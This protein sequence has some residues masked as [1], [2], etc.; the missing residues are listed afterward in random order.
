LLSGF[1]I[2]R[3]TLAGDRWR[4]SL[5]IVGSGKTSL[6]T[7]RSFGDASGEAIGRYA[8][9][10]PAPELAGLV[11]AAGATLDGGPPPRLS[12]EDVR[13]VITIVACGSQLT[14]VV[15]GGPPALEPYQPL[16]VAL[17][18][19]AVATR[20]QPQAVV[21]L[22]LE[23]PPLVAAGPHTL[24][25]VL[26]FHNPGSAGAWLRNPAAI[27]EDS[28]REHVRL[29][30]AERPVEQ[31]GV[32]PLPLEPAW[33]PVVPEMRA[34]RPLL[35]LGPGEREARPFTAQL[36]LDPGSYLV[37]ASFA[38]YAG[39]DSVGGQ[40]LLRGCVFSEEHV[41]EVRG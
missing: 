30:Y 2:E 23:L 33:V 17:D 6:S 7:L 9:A 34:Q 3:L 18:R 25:T 20:R 38:S 41:L 31:P 1:G 13:L 29:W 8:S 15:G 39:E 14:H 35:W 12:P 16:L 4:E 22:G 27:D 11:D 26:A 24:A 40:P 5:S 36:T 10:L 21:R 32:T 19:V 37:R 28:E